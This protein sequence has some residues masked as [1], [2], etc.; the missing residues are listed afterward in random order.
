MIR[1]PT[2][3]QTSTSHEPQFTPPARE[4]PSAVDIVQSIAVVAVAVPQAIHWAI[5][6]R[7]KMRHG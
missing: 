2:G 4:Q 7:R 1:R 3:L 6:K 5:S